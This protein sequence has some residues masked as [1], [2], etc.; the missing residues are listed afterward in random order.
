MLTLIIRSLLCHNYRVETSSNPEKKIANKNVQTSTKQ[1]NA[2]TAG[3]G[4][5]TT[6]RKQQIVNKKEQDEKVNQQGLRTPIKTTQK[7]GT[8]KSTRIATEPKPTTKRNLY[9]QSEREPC[10]HCSIK[11][12]LSFFLF[13]FFLFF[14]FTIYLDRKFDHAAFLRHV[15][16]CKKVKK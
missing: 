10:P 15:D 5:M 9:Q 13:L 7:L 11:F 16:I 2:S 4:N 1:Q 14:L 3:K 6:T 12:F 8:N